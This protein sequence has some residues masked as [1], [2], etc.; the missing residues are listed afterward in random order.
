MAQEL[1]RQDNRETGHQVEQPTTAPVQS[2]EQAGES[3]ATVDSE[4]LLGF[5]VESIKDYA[6]FAIDPAG[7]VISW[8]AGAEHIFGYRQDEIIGQPSDVIY[9]PEDRERGVPAQERATAMQEGRALDERMNVTERKQ[10]EAERD[11]LL[12]REQEARREAE[13]ANRAKDEF[14]AT[15]SHELRTPLNAILGWARLLTSGN[16]ADAEA[17]AALKT[18]DRNAQAQAQL[19]ED[20]LD[21]SRIISGKLRLE[22][23]LVDLAAVVEAAVDTAIPAAEAKRILLRG[24]VDAGAI[25]VLGD[26]NR[27]QQVVGNLL[28]NALK[29][30]PTGGLVQAQLERD[31]TQ[32]RIIVTDTGQGIGPEFLPHVFDRFRQANSTST[33]THG[34]LGLGLA[35]VRHL[36]ELHGGR[37]EVESPGLGQGAT[38]II[39]LPLAV[40]NALDDGQVQGPER[41][42]RTKVKNDLAR[43]P[44]LADLRILVVDD[45]A[46]ARQL[47][48]SIIEQCG[49]H[50]HAVSSVSEAIRAV[51]QEPPDLIV[52][53]IGMPDEDGYGLISRLRALPPERGGRVPA[54]ALTAYARV[55]DRLRVLG[56]GFQMH[57]PKPV[58]PA[59]LVAVLSSLAAW[60]D[61]HPD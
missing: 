49:A 7:Q 44:A 23:R 1:A 57:V 21:V 5:M 41:R 12:I 33:R 47:L 27:L 61:K 9:T 60:R 58:D 46:D 8:N 56:A 52:S 16:L 30:T 39:K 51:E 25:T 6:I 42:T 4:E 22:T 17:E 40:V 59:E 53:D 43:P 32:A 38:F 50:A 20:I 29:F 3:L 18:I 10:A 15:L 54:V 11:S 45:E 19:I 34:G 14:L 13:T 26:A 37:V 36:T 35:I 48:V 24:V 55:E 31:E 2:P 28:S